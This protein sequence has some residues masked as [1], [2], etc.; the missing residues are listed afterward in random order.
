MKKTSKPKN[1]FGKKNRL[2]LTTFLLLGVIIIGLASIVR[3]DIPASEVI[4]KH[5]YANSA[6]LPW[7]NS[8]I[9]YR[10][11]GSGPS[12]VLI[13]GTSSSLHTWETWMDTLSKDFEVVALDL[14]GFGLTGPHPEGKYG[15][16]DYSEAVFTLMDSLKIDQAA[17]AGNSLGGMIAWHMGQ[18]HPDRVSQLILIDAVGFDRG[19]TTFT[20]LSLGKIPVIKEIFKYATPRFMIRNSLEDVYQ[21]D[22]LITDELVDLYHDMV[23]REGNRKALVDRLNSPKTAKVKPDPQRLYMPILLMW[24]KTDR[25]VPLAH[26][27]SFQQSL[28]HAELKVY[29]AGHV[30]MEELGSLTAQDASI[31]LNTPE[32]QPRTIFPQSD[33]LSVH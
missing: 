29:E 3:W 31:F 20:V 32:N 15:I 2:K 13:H 14:P 11:M 7:K 8:K 21:N 26:A 22:S 24:G 12:V 18:A 4:K 16:E 33:S 9:H 25:W 1:F 5:S 30:P 19:D 28:P 6:F 23:L 17:I 27:D 10:R